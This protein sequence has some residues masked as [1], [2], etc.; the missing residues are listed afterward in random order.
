VPRTMARLAVAQ[1]FG[2]AAAAAAAVQGAN[3]SKQPKTPHILFLL[4]DGAYWAAAFHPV[5]CGP[6]SP[7]RL[8]PRCLPPRV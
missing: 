5:L 1:L 7:R 4:A 2:A 8:A 3:A 6:H